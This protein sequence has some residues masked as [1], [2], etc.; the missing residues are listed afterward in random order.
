MKPVLIIAEAGVNHNGSLKTA[1]ELVDI[2]VDAGADIVKFQYFNPKTLVAPNARKADYQIENTKKGAEENQFSMLEKL[3]LSFDE[4]SQVAE[5]CAKMGIEYLC[6]PFCEADLD[7]IRPLIT[8]IK[9]PSGELTN[10]PFLEYSAK[11]QL[12]IILSTGMATTQEIIESIEVIYSTCLKEEAP[13]PQLD[14]LQCNTAY[15]TP[16]EDV[17]LA[18]IPMLR[19]TL[20][21]IY[22]E[23]YINIGYSDHTLGIEVP[24]AAV[25][26]GST[27]IEKHFTIHRDS[28]GPDHRASLEPLELK[29]MVTSIRNIEQAIGSGIKRPQTS[30][31]VNIAIAR[32]SWHYSNDLTQ[33]SI[34]KKQDL[35]LLR[36][37]HGF[38]PSQLKELIGQSLSANISQYDIVELNNFIRENH[39]N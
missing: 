13:F 39:E 6:T 27:I 1:L 32:K 37:G 25:A 29:A 21:S 36:P 26:L 33:G 17:N 4:H 31:K 12:P 9:I 20:R 35:V 8:K 22:P 5:Y 15:P 28:D 18:V 2:A 11:A 10:H 38:K 19:Q 7:I 34:L 16:F 30:E 14:I 24:I 23:L 3:C